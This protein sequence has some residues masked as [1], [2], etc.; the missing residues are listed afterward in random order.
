MSYNPVHGDYDSHEILTKRAKKGAIDRGVIMGMY[1]CI[2]IIK[3]HY[4]SYYVDYT[5]NYV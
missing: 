1:V 3:I 4:M 5:Y 2:Y